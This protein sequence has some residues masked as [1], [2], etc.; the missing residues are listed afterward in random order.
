MVY[1]VTFELKSFYEDEDNNL[2]ALVTKEYEVESLEELFEI[3]D[4][5]DEICNIDDSEVI[6][7]DIEESPDDVNIEYVLIH[8]EK[9][10]EVYRDEDYQE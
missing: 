10:E 6:D 2:E 7:M 3:L 1:T 4:D 5:T 9:G 8:D